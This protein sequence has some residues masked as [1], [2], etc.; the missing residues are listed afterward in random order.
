MDRKIA[1]G[2][3]RICHGE[4]GRELT[5]M[6][7]TMYNNDQIVRGR[8]LLAVVVRYYASNNSGQVLYDLN[9]LQSLSMVGDNVEGFRNA[10]NMV[11]AELSSTPAEE[12]RQYLYYH[13]IKDFKP[14]AADVAH[15]LRAEWNSGPEHCFQWLWDA[16][17][18]DIKQRRRDHMQD[19]LNKSLHSRNHSQAA[20]GVVP[21]GRGKG[22]RPKGNARAA[23]KSRSA[24]PNRTPKGGDR[25][26]PKG[27]PR[28]R[29]VDSGGKGSD[30]PR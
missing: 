30:G 28:G 1:T 9:H 5:Q 6:S 16:T 26:Q 19:S 2:L 18:R 25:G 8:S 11:M 23:A 21:S 20:L 15:F 3:M 12:A 10:W 7:T 4:L 17:C 27:T 14:M 29:A 13:Q 24:I 22:D